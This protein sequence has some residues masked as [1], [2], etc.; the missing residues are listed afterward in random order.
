MYTLRLGSLTV[1]S[2]PALLRMVVIQGGGQQPE[3]RALSAVV[4]GPLSHTLREVGRKGDG[5]ASWPDCVK[6]P[7]VSEYS[8]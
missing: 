8:V 5:T 1:A 3:G 2:A 7:E 4:G 6:P